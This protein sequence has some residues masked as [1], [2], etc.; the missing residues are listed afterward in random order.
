LILKLL[1][2]LSQRFNCYE[3]VHAVL[4]YDAIMND[5]LADEVIIKLNNNFT[6]ALIHMG[7]KVI[8]KMHMIILKDFQICSR[9]LG[10]SE[11]WR[12]IFQTSTSKAKSFETFFQKSLKLRFVAMRRKLKSWKRI[13]MLTRKKW[14]S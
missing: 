3:I 11:I 5:T 2:E 9:I 12:K 14:C 10:E 6:L 1:L 7:T 8:I 4:S 13:M